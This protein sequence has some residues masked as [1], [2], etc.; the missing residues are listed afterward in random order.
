MRSVNADVANVLNEG[1]DALATV[2]YFRT[3]EGTGYEGASYDVHHFI[4][5]F[6]EPYGDQPELQIAGGSLDTNARRFDYQALAKFVLQNCT[7]DEDKRWWQLLRRRSEIPCTRKNIP[8]RFDLAK[9]ASFTVPSFPPPR[10][11]IGSVV[12]DWIGIAGLGV[13]FA[14]G[15]LCLFLLGSMLFRL[16]LGLGD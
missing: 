13:I 14:L 16:F 15:C 5:R 2:T 7:R 8:V 3:S 12:G 6:P 11:G 9:P 4:F 1:T 10:E